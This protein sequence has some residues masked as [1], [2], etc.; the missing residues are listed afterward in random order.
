MNGRSDPT[1]FLIP[2]HH[3]VF[4]FYHLAALPDLPPFYHIRCD[5]GFLSPANP[6][7]DDYADLPTNR[8]AN[9]RA[10]ESRIEPNKESLEARTKESTN[11]R[12]HRPYWF[13]R[14]TI[15]NHFCNFYRAVTGSSPRINP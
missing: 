10:A 1:C 9:Q 4:T 8:R 6:D 14:F 13:Y 12:T 11:E 3:T 7:V 15:F 2:P 5:S